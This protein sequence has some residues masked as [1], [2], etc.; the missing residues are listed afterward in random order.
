MGSFLD[1]IDSM[2]CLLTC[3]INL[4]PISLSSVFLICREFI[5]LL[6]VEI[7][8]LC[9]GGLLRGISLGSSEGI[10]CW[11]VSCYSS[12]QPLVVPV[13][14]NVLGRLFNVLG[15]TID[16]FIE[17]G[18]GDLFNHK[19]LSLILPVKNKPLQFELWGEFGKAG[20]VSKNSMSRCIALPGLYSPLSISCPSSAG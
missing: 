8:Q 16:S 12:Y 5:N 13:G 19:A 17:I 1:T 11:K 10:S 18:S 7:S 3:L 20:W 15:S 9:F 14:R 2:E 6:E 4:T